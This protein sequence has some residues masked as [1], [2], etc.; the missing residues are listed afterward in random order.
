VFPTVREPAGGLPRAPDR[1]RGLSVVRPRRP[2][3]RT[4]VFELDDGSYRMR[5]VSSGLG[6]GGRRG[7]AEDGGG[8]WWT[9]RVAGDSW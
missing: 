8:R 5:H 1:T 6:G 7:P 3:G 9:A 4:A 2:K